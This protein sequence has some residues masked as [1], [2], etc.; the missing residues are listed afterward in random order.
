MDII[1]YSKTQ[2]LEKK[3]DLITPD[4]YTVGENKDFSTFTAMLIA[5]ENDD[6]DKIVYVDS[7]TYDIFD[8]IGG[9]EYMEEIAPTASELGWRDV[10]HVVPPNTKIVGLG[11]VVLE[12]KPTAEQMISTDVA[13]LFSPLNISGSCEIENINVVAQNCRYPVHDETSGKSE[14]NGAKH[15]YRNCRFTLLNGTYGGTVYGA[16][17]N[18]LMTLIFDNCIFDCQKE[19]TIWSTHDWTNPKDENSVFI[20][21]SCVFT[22]PKTDPQIVFQSNDTYGRKDIVQLNNCYLEKIMFTT[23]GE[24]A[25]QGYDVTLIGCTKTIIDYSENVTDKYTVK[26]YNS[27]SKPVWCTGISLNKNNVTFN[28]ID[29]TDTLVATVSPV[30]TTEEVVW[31]SSNS[32]VCTVDLGVITAK[33]Y[34]NATI[35]ATCGA[36]SASCSVYVSDE[37]DYVVV[38]GYIPKRL[39]SDGDAS[40]ISSDSTATSSNTALATNSSDTSIYTIANNMSPDTSPYRFVPIRIPNNAVG[41]RLYCENYTFKTYMLWFDRTQLNTHPT[42]PGSAKVLAGK[43]DSTGW[44]QSTWEHEYIVAIPDVAGINS[45]AAYVYLNNINATTHTDVTS[46]LTL[47]FLTELPT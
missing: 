22:S 23:G 20:F 40:G 33:D 27:I 12:W 34:G 46:E 7:G 29:D 44:D 14:Y 45:V 6:S 8:E 16:G 17:H 39:S 5:L 42:R 15:I 25:K 2:N 11:N 31:Y 21:N 19:K 26:Q 36:Y 4:V 38:S 1:T 30:N 43:A 24:S 3:L 18:K 37:I 9:A 10:C 32:S 35:T 13:R 47:Q 41:V 28:D